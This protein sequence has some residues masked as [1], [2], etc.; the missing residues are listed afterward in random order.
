MDR[1]GVLRDVYAEWE[2]G[3]YR[4][5]VELY[6]PAMTLVVHSPIPDAGVYD[7][8]VA[9]QR[10]MR[11]FLE[12][13]EDYKIQAVNLAP[14][15]DQVVVQVHHGGRASGAWAEMDFFAVWS[16]RGDSVIRID[17]AQRRDVA[18]ESARAAAGK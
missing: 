17:F 12:T 9:L 6:D 4:A 13:W 10:Y 5:G 8:L 11:R 2:R 15:D 18:V 1:I 16:F 3:N 14:E 7:G